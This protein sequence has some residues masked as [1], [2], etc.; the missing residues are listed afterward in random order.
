MRRDFEVVNGIENLGE[1]GPHGSFVEI[2]HTNSYLD[3]NLAGSA[4]PELYQRALVGLKKSLG[5]DHTSTLLTASNLGRLY[6]AQGKLN[7]AEKTYPQA[8][9]GKEKALGADHTSTLD[10]V[11]N[12]RLFY[13]DQDKLGETE[14]MHRRALLGFQESLG[15]SHPST[16]TIRKNLKEMQA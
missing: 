6:G 8:L 4:E 3:S 16:I 12:L 14:K 7:E 1:I 13:R 11:N 15:S 10:T 9:A 5:A 2:E